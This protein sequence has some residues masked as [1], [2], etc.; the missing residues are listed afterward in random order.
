MVSFGV[1]EFSK[2]YGDL[3]PSQFVDMVSLTGDKTDNIPGLVP[4]L[5]IQN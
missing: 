2:R 3:K 4:F 5:K 1:E